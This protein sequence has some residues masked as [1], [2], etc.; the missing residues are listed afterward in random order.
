[1]DGINGDGVSPE[2]NPSYPNWGYMMYYDDDPAST[3]YKKVVLHF[4]TYG[5][6]AGESYTLKTAA[7]DTILDPQTGQPI[8]DGSLNTHWFHVGLTY[9]GTTLILY[10]NG[11]N[12]ASLVAGGDANLWNY[13]LMMGNQRYV[14][15]G[16]GRR[17]LQ[18]WMDEIAL[19]LSLIHI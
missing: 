2:T 17:V 6:P 3:D 11:V 5:Q 13:Y 8:Y 19:Y 7:L 15:A 16:G 4:R 14:V 12:R 1:M 10:L 18:G 9:D